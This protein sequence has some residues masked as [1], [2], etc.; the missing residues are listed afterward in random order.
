MDHPDLTVSN[1]MEKSIDLKGV[2]TL[3]S[4]IFLKYCISG[5]TQA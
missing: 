2:S 1:L 4:N 5:F 3:G